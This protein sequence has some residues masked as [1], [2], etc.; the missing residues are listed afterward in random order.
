MPDRCCC[1]RADIQG[2]NV[3]ILYPGGEKRDDKSFCAFWVQ[4]VYDMI[5]DQA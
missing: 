4:L 1:D 3:T 2:G 5:P